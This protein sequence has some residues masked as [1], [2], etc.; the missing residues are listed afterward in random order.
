ML[1]ILIWNRMSVSQ[2]VC[3]SMCKFN[4]ELVGSSLDCTFEVRNHCCSHLLSMY[5]TVYINVEGQRRNCM[6][7][8]MFKHIVVI[9]FRSL[10]STSLALRSAA[11]SKLKTTLYFIIVRALESVFSSASLLEVFSLP[12][13][14][15]CATESG[16][17]G[18]W[19]LDIRH[20]D[21]DGTAV[22]SC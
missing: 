16:Q 12:R 8:S 6:S 9:H 10:T 5:C 18:G 11:L 20:V 3:N 4:I 13:L 7:I 22:G 19:S 17:R 21:A 2:Y 1:V 15:A 14:A